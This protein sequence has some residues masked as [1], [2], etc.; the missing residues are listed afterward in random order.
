MSSTLERF[1]EKYPYYKSWD[2]EKLAE[3]FR[4]KYYSDMPVDEYRQKIGLKPLPKDEPL[5]S[6]DRLDRKLSQ[7]SKNGGSELVVNPSV[8]DAESEEEISD[9]SNNLRLL[10]ERGGK[11]A[12]HA[13]RG[14]VGAPGD[15][16]ENNFWGMGGI[17]FGSDWGEGHPDT[18]K[19]RIRYM[20]EQEFK[21]FN[22]RNPGAQLL[23]DQ[24]PERL[25]N[26]DFGGEDRHTPEKI[27]EAFGRKDVL[28]TAKA[29]WDFSVQQGVTS[30]PDIVALMSG[31][32][33]FSA[34]VAARSDE[35][36]EARAE[37]KGKSQQD[38]IDNLEAAPWALG[39]AALDRF[40]A[41]KV[42]EAFGKESIKEIGEDILEGGLKAAAKRVGKK[43]GTATAAEASTEFIQEGV[44][45]YLGEKLNTNA[46]LSFKE[47]GER[48]LFGAIAGGTIG[49]TVSG[50]GAT[51]SE[52]VSA[53]DRSLIN[54]IERNT[55]AKRSKTLASESAMVPP[56]QPREYFDKRLKR[57]T[58][59]YRLAEMAERSTDENTADN[60][61]KK[62]AAKALTGQPLGIGE[63]KIVQSMLDQVSAERAAPANVDH[64][65]GMLNEAR[66]QRQL[67]RETHKLPPLDAYGEV[68]GEMLEEGEYFPE[69]DGETRIIADLAAIGDAID[70]ARVTNIL[71]TVANNQEAITALEGF[72]NDNQQYQASAVVTE[73]D[74][75]T[76]TPDQV[77][78]TS[79]G[80]AIEAPSREYAGPERRQQ[81]ARRAEIKDLPAS[82]AKEILYT[83]PLTGLSNERAFDDLAS[84]ASAVAA[85]NVEGVSSV[86]R[87][88]GNDRGDGL[89]VAVGEAL[90]KL[91][92]NAFRG[93]GDTFY[94]TGDS[95]PELE[96]AI[97]QAKADLSR[98]L[99]DTPEGK[100]AGLGISHGMGRNKV[101]A[102]SQLR[103]NK[104]ARE[105]S[106][107]KSA[108]GVLPPGG[109]LYSSP[110]IDSAPGS[111]YVG[112]IGKHGDLPISPNQEYILGNGK[113]VKIPTKPVR[114]ED[115]LKTMQRKFGL[116][117][118]QG[119]IKGKTRLGFYRLNTGEIRIKSAND[120][121]VTAHEVAHWLDDR[122]PW[123]NKLYKKHEPEMRGVSYDS[124]K[125]HE[126]YAEFMRLWFTQ[127][128]KA[129]NA[130]P[131]FYDAWMKELKKYPE[132]LTLIEEIQQQMHAWHLQ[133]ADARLDSVIG[134][135]QL[136]IT[137]WVDRILRRKMDRV[138]QMVFDGLRPFKE[139]EREMRG[140]VEN[141]ATSGYATLRL[142]AGAHGV[143][144][145][146]LHKGTINWDE[147]GDIEF[148]G[149]GLNDVFAP[150]SN[151][152][153]EMQK[154]MIA[155]RAQELSEQ[156][157]E[158][159]LRPDQIA[160]GLKYGDDPDITK[161]FDE[162][163]EFN[164]RMMDFY[165]S[166]GLIGSQSRKAVEEMN[167]NYV[168][169]N[170]VIET[171]LGD[172][173]KA[174]RGSP[175]VRLKGGTQNIN[176]VFESIVGNTSQMVHMA[177]I[178]K[179]KVNFYEMILAD[180]SQTAGKY[181]THISKEVK[182]TK[183]QSDQVIKTAVE[184]MGLTMR[185]YR[186][187]KTGMVTSPE[188]AMAV[189]MID[190]MAY[191]LDS[192]VTFFQTGQD[193]TGNVD[194]FLRDGEKVFFEIGDPY[195]YDAIKHIGPQ[196]YNLSLSIL[197]GFA[198][199]LRRG[200]TTTPTFQ[201]KNF[202]RDTMN[203]F[204]LSKG[205]IIPAAGAAKE[206]ARRFYNDE[207]YWEYMAN[208]GG[209]AAMADADGISRDRVLDE[210][211]K[212][213]RFLDEGLA[214]FEYAN[215]MAEFT[216]LREK[217]WSAR[218]AALAGR[219]ISS[220]FAMRG[221]SDF[222]RVFTVSVP[223]LNA[224]LQG[225]YRN[226]R[227]VASLEKGKLKLTGELA[228]SYA[229]RSLVS[230]TLPTLYLYWLNHD[231]ERYQ[232]LPDWIKDLSWVIFYGPGEDDYVMIPKPFE[233]G[234][235]W[236]TI[237]ERTME[238]LYT[239]DQKEL[240]DAM[241]WMI[242][243]T[244]SV[245][246]VPQAFKPLYDLERNKNFTGAPIIPQYLKEVE[247]SEQYRHYTSEALIALGRKLNISPIK[248]EHL[249]RGY[250]G[251][252][253][254]WALGAADMMV[255]DVNDWGETPEKGIKDNILLSPFVND[256]P[257]RRTDSEDDLWQM[258]RE[259]HTVVNT[260]RSI[261]ART[262]GR[263]EHYI[264]QPEK[265]VLHSLNQDLMGWAKEMREIN[266]TMDMVRMD[267]TMTGNQ[268]KME[269]EELQRHK[270]QIAFEVRKNINPKS[271]G[272]FVDQAKGLERNE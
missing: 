155:R 236:A 211:N 219:E 90:K 169:F 181:A 45:E 97:S 254:T 79:E 227:E 113:P 247:P 151:R 82:Q 18:G 157:R 222:L 214:T 147:N 197:G 215:R 165:E 200:V 128:F 235:V 144:Q 192:L 69:M 163:L 119:R 146:I 242:S 84:Y 98:Q 41:K 126:G 212:I 6:S 171:S 145:A 100:V 62:A 24:L 210:K 245:N 201:A 199:V 101:E 40:G 258:L 154:Y 207:H 102:E 81:W 8:N 137:D 139:I 264:S 112:L 109:T 268:K 72:L 99:L 135:S 213:F 248:A 252:W 218:D 240:A 46:D 87:H 182:P 190:K 83:D 115:I 21:E 4:V 206:L 249:V 205:H 86:N 269:L 175:F 2:N 164:N 67:L 73:N 15:Y 272:R 130:A 251:T 266:N 167:K 110:P 143:M 3:A 38:L 120:L 226:A 68:V 33:G 142:A 177:L 29:V 129:R 133:G 14:I 17:V 118:Y 208:G 37:N 54:K 103:E 9:L 13:V 148:T 32:G 107:T 10:G 58:Y 188:E 265:L 198:N 261:E 59:R 170:R 193:P 204:T 47:A 195:L 117:I 186:A 125:I 70:S 25:K 156:G 106:G 153:Q 149:K 43:M 262:P 91:G 194:Y 36:G 105:A 5:D 30:I 238:Y 257:L 209:F 180:K 138:L 95:V 191:G 132:L 196:P 50:A 44:L 255:G 96:Q 152:M 1:K 88:F 217:G 7:K 121:E 141:A 260:L 158:N 108:K 150:V 134:R 234:T 57:E 131:G 203:A 244:F 78:S 65:K 61:I 183:I 223:F 49:A 231:D 26:L 77:Y 228:F 250:L 89:I 35:I 48:G 221:A 64:A 31:V 174:G 176:D 233:T 52:I 53:T 74:A 253:G 12:G 124:E 178:N 172:K 127:D 60:E 173:P 66:K 11:L 166:S 22:A 160:A 136:S 94:I 185:W 80:Q 179:G 85:I 241:L 28:G 51:G 162:W 116:K 23:K 161:A 202:I 76:T 122:Y 111:T 42:F 55:E 271:I 246:P 56:E 92:V 187:A 114:R 20:D 232:Q 159:L 239:H 256:G 140:Q 93:K 263:Y 75:S 16:A 184:G 243:S 104:Q 224:R 27:K 123:I 216:A 225:L 267:K 229:L 71:S 19:F 63:T 237:P 259:T 220:D 189:A 168:P 39:S 270:N 230:I 34:Y